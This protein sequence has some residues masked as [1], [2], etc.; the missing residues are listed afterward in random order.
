MGWGVLSLPLSA[1]KQTSTPQESLGML[2]IY[3]TFKADKKEISF[4]IS[5]SARIVKDYGG[6][7]HHLAPP[8]GSAL[9]DEDGH[10]MSWINTGIDSDYIDG[11]PSED[12]ELDA[13]DSRNPEPWG[14]EEEEGEAFVM[15][16][17]R[18]RQQSAVQNDHLSIDT[19]FMPDHLKNSA[20]SHSRY[21]LDCFR[22]IVSMPKRVVDAIKS[23]SDLATALQQHVELKSKLEYALSLKVAKKSE[24]IEL[25][26]SMFLFPGQTAII[27]TYQH[28]VELLPPTRCMPKT[29]CRNIVKR[30]MQPAMQPFLAPFERLSFL[31]V[32]PELY[33][34]IVASQAGHA[35]LITLTRLDVYSSNGPVVNF[36]MDS[37]VPRKQEDRQGGSNCPLYGMAVAPL[38]SSREKGASQGRRW[39][40]V[41]HYYDHTV[42]SYEIS[43]NGESDE[44]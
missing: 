5:L 44:L 20:S 36:R 37:I 8:L 19:K 22:Y 28:D 41:L 6:T 43:R 40:L 2:D 31:T 38:Q 21:A 42:L 29:I 13:R 24:S 10:T 18:E 1:F 23:T 35:A 26:D 15:S 3:N 17:L 34:L 39:R 11:V 16:L 25:E 14:A 33:L 7:G 32:I 4:D 9:S 30:T 27:R 12:D